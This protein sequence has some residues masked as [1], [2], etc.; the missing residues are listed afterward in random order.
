MLYI[1]IIM[2]VLDVDKLLNALDNE[3]NENIMKFNSDKISKLKND[4][5]QKLG[6]SR[7]NLIKLHKSLKWYK[8]IDELPEVNYG[9]YIRWI[10]LKDP[11]N[12]KLTT[13]GI[14]CDIKLDNKGIVIICKNNCNRFFQLKMDECLVFQ[15]LTDQ[16]RVIITALDYL[17]K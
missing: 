15:K 9:C 12:I 8:L 2:T 13:G 5:L 6:L 11:S 16:E 1:K 7:E 17:N 3:N 10:S 14:I 4:V